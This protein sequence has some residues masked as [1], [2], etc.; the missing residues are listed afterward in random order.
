MSIED[1]TATRTA[2]KQAERGPGIQ[3]DA[4]TEVALRA[5]RP[6]ADAATEAALRADRR[7]ADTTWAAARARFAARAV[8]DGLVTLAYEDHETPLGPLRIGATDA[9]IVR[10]VLP[11]E[12]ADEVLG[13][14]AETVS[15]RILRT[16]TSHLTKARR[17]LDEYF[18]RDR[19]R[20]D[21][22]LDWRL[23]RAFRLDVLRA[24]AAI[25]YGST[26]SYKGVATAAGSPSAVRAAGTALATNPLPVLVP[27]HRVVKSDGGLGRYLGGVAMK[28][29]LLALEGV[30]AA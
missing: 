1:E 9:G 11:A 24:T 12:D 5:D 17:E 16:S 10:V 6:A 25:P 13:R 20:F 2:G 26:A 29:E 22:P 27:C 3:G 28:T 14:L 15:A 4:A 19:E 18:A 23:S 21:V 30:I 8:A 7:P